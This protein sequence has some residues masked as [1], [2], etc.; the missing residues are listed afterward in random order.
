MATAK[1]GGRGHF[2]GWL[3]SGR[4]HAAENLNRIAQIFQPDCLIQS[5]IADAF[6]PIRINIH[7]LVR[8]EQCFN[9]RPDARK[10]GVKIIPAQIAK[11]QMNNPRRRRL[12]DNPVGEIRVLADDCQFIFAGKFP[13]LRVAWL[14]ADFR[15]RNDWKFRRKAQPRRQIFV[16]EKTLHAVCTTEK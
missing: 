16:K 4:A 2:Q 10:Q 13:N 3:Q 12:R 8:F 11:P 7:Q 14:F 5:R 15:N 1:T 9:L 6:E